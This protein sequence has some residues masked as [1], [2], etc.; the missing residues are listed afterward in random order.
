MV[1]LHTRHRRL[2]S[3]DRRLGAQ[4]DDTG[5][6]PR[7]AQGWRDLNCQNDSTLE[8]AREIVE[9][10]LLGVVVCALIALAV[11]GSIA[12]LG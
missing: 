7:H 6:T 8:I 10:A 5:R 1:S 2:L 3:A 12:L 4:V 11:L 9:A